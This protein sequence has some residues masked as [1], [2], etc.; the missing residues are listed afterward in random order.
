MLEIRRSPAGT[1]AWHGFIS[2]LGVPTIE[3]PDGSTITEERIVHEL[4]HI[5]QRVRGF[6]VGVVFQYH[7]L[8][9]KTVAEVVDKLRPMLESF[10]L[11]TIEHFI[12]FR[13]MTAM[14]MDAYA[15][16][17]AAIREQVASDSLP[18]AVTE[19][20]RAGIGVEGHALWG[21]R[22]ALEADDPKIVA[23]WDKSAIV[24]SEGLRAGKALAQ[25]VT[26]RQPETPQETAEAIAAALNCLLGSIGS[27]TP[28]GWHETQK[29]SIVEK[30]VIVLVHG[31]SA[32]GA[33][34]T[35]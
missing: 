25:I 21:F 4:F 11:D 16:S 20:V 12:F 2:D 8:S 18:A 1:S 27:F 13:Q 24:N 6:P 19:A 5:D 33:C 3:A 14:R 31:P 34:S 30:R 26:S 17:R 32:D 15:T 22:V 35:N 23:A 7:S 28:F 10:F 9:P 29:G